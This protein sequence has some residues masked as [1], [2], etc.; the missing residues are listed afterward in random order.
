MLT[1][2]KRYVYEDDDNWT[3]KTEDGMPAAHFE[4]TVLVTD[5]GYV[6]LTGE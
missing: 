1:Y 6:I 5:D 2:G 3:I 4:H